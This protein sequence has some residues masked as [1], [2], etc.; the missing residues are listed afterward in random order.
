M[1]F[2]VLYDTNVSKP[3]IKLWWPVDLG[4]DE[5]QQTDLLLDGYAGQMICLFQRGSITMMYVYS[6]S[7]WTSSHANKELVPIGT[8]RQGCGS[9]SDMQ[10]DISQSQVI[11]QLFRAMVDTSGSNTIKLFKHFKRKH[12]KEHADRVSLRLVQHPH[13]PVS[14][15]VPKR[16]LLSLTDELEHSKK[17]N[18]S[19]RRLKEVTECDH[20]RIRCRSKL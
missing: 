10:S 12:P 6:N 8:G 20:L 13:P 17:Y 4:Y 19:R 14:H 5:Y 3:H 7:T 18:K 9:G 1:T 11:C 2:Y 16:K 15:E